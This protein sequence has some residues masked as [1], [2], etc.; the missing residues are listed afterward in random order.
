MRK[1]RKQLVLIPPTYS[2]V[3]IKGVV[4]FRRGQMSTDDNQQSA[5]KDHHVVGKGYVHL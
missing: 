3:K 1:C 4:D 5:T 2:T